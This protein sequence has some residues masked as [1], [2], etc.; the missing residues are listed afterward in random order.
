[1]YQFALFSL[2]LLTMCTSQTEKHTNKILYETNNPTKTATLSSDLEEISGITFWDSETLAAIND[3]QGKVFFISGNNGEI[4]SELEFN[5][6]GDYEDIASIN[7]EIWVVRSDGKLYKFN[8]DED[9]K[10]ALTKFDTKL[11]EDNNIEGLC[12]YAASNQ[13][14]LACKEDPNL[15][16]NP[17][18]KGLRAIYAFDLQTEKLINK[19]VFTFNEDSIMHLVHL[20][21][22]DRLG[23]RFKPSAIGVNPIDGDIFILSAINSLL[24]VFDSNRYYKD[25]IRLPSKHLPQAESLCFDPEGNLYIASEGSGGK[26]HLLYFQRKSK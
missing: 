20:K 11:N 1:M 16:D 13:L 18:M 24:L 17:K 23:D 9:S 5:G 14:W 7:G 4:I 15:N 25:I 2:M 12:Y 3:E 21:Y 8:G 10:L 22:G 26:A 19:P 6:P